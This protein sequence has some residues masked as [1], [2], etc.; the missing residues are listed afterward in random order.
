VKNPR[1]Q[2]GSTAQADQWLEKH[3]ESA[4]D[5]VRAPYGFA[6]KVMDAVYR[7][8]LAE[9]SLA[10][11]AA[12]RGKLRAQAVRASPRPTVSRM[13]RRLGL[14]FVLTAAVLTVS[15]LIPHG[16]Y[17]MLINSG[18]ADTALGAGPSAA[19]QNALSGA[20]QAVQGALGEQQIG[21]NQQ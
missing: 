5:E 12:S 14:S 11:Q 10:T 21:G 9:R 2:H 17:P 15:L 1:A 19:V 4:R 18:G 16:A 3:L 20:A 8:S 7:E 6:H 13:Y